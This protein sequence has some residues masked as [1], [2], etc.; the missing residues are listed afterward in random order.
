[1][2]VLLQRVAPHRSSLR[3]PEMVIYLPE[4]TSHLRT[5]LQ[6]PTIQKSCWQINMSTSK[7]FSNV[8]GQEIVRASATHASIKM[9]V[10]E[11]MN[12]PDILEFEA[13]L[14]S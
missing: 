9:I 13:V 11:E 3:R 2:I 10:K 12:G 6:L 8:F 4:I 14:L 5:L 7:K 1:M